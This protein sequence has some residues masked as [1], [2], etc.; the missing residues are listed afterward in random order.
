MPRRRVR[1]F[2][3]IIGLAM[4]VAAI[5][6]TREHTVPA[7]FFRQLTNTDTSPDLILESI[8]AR[9]NGT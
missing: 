5:W 9:N 8:K 7:E 1:T 6:R 3:L 2:A 4:S